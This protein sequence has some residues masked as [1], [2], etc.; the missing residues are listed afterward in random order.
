MRP[1]SGSRNRIE[2][3]GKVLGPKKGGWPGDMRRPGA[4]S[5]TENAGCWML[6][7]SLNSQSSLT[8]SPSQLHTG[9]GTVGW[10]VGDFA[11]SAQQKVARPDESVGKKSVTS[12][13]LL[14]DTMRQ[15]ELRR[16][17]GGDGAS[18]HL[19][20]ESCCAGLGSVCCAGVVVA[21]ALCFGTWGWCV[22][23]ASQCVMH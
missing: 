23:C 11:V 22:L 7:C 16:K 2:K 6:G 1:N 9:G 12:L 20:R 19:P 13:Q 3:D 4:G 17:K 10:A 15:C 21:G 18:R 5:G 14:S 8:P